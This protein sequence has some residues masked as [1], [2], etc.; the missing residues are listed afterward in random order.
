MSAP[1]RCTDGHAVCQYI[2]IVNLLKLKG[3]EKVFNTPNM[4]EVHDSANAANFVKIF[5]ALKI[6]CQHCKTILLTEKTGQ[7]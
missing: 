5:D 6:T 4:F 7:I 2:D 1:I 3:M